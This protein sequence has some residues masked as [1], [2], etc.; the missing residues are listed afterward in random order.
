MS[1]FHRIR[2][3]FKYLYAMTNDEKLEILEK[4]K[5]WFREFAVAHVKNA[6]KLKRL[7]D[8]KPNPFLISY[9]SYFHSGNCSPDS[10]AKVLIYPRV[11]GT[12]INTSFGGAVQTMTH[13]LLING[14]ASAHDGV[15]IE[16][17]DA[18]DN[19]R[20]YAQLKSGPITI[21]KDDGPTIT[22][23]FDA[24]LG[25]ARQ[26]R[27]PITSQD[28]L[29]GIVYGKRSDLHGGYRK[30]EEKYEV[31]IGQEFWT[32]LTGDSDFYYDLIDAV[33]EIA[34]ETNGKELLEQTIATLAKDP[35]IIELSAKLSKR[36]NDE[37]PQV[38]PE[39][40]AE[41]KAD[42]DKPKPED[43]NAFL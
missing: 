32:A 10:I 20:K 37:H 14:Y 1:N 3:P 8:F 31:L 11:L 41:I 40:V 7:K 42:Q 16:F 26:N 24:I 23:K 19:R 22:T 28:L 38:I 5:A 27:L 30:I 18:R 17:I 12:S 35:G 9:L 13:E 25:R 36:G 33:A 34:F 2:P 21:N 29:V 39:M 4:A 15:D 6:V 43:L